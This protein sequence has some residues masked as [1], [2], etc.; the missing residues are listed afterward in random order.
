MSGAKQSRTNCSIRTFRAFSFQHVFH[1]SFRFTFLFH[2]ATRGYIICFLLRVRSS[3]MNGRVGWC[4]M[5]GGL[6]KYGRG[7]HGL[8]I[9][10]DISVLSPFS[11]SFLHSA[12]VDGGDLLGYN[13]RVGAFSFVWVLK[14]VIC[15]CCLCLSCFVFRG[16]LCGYKNR[17][18]GL[19]A[20]RG[21]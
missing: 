14:S 9:Q 7:H 11:V 10:M 12:T 21:K 19:L 8:A 17:I 2:L 15:T 1:L 3:W 5:F 20:G 18:S 6:E 4:L 16:D 13:S